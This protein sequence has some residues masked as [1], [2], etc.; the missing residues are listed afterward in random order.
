MTGAGLVQPGALFWRRMNSDDASY[1]HW[2]IGLFIP[3]KFGLKIGKMTID[4]YKPLK[5]NDF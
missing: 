3:D 1:A 2:A 5:N 4:F